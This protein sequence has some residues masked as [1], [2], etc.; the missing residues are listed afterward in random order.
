M[1]AGDS[2]VRSG[3]NRISK[4]PRP[5]FASGIGPRLSMMAVLAQRTAGLDRDISF[6]I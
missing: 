2:R 4:P 6:A 5:A 3:A 1:L